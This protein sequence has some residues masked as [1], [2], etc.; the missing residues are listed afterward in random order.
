M[1]LLYFAHLLGKTTD[2]LSVWSSNLI[3]KKLLL[4]D[5]RRKLDFQYC[6][7]EHIVSQQNKWEKP[8]IYVNTGLQTT[9]LI[10]VILKAKS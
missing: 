4:K 9:Q 2:L 8:Q 5:H 10:R 1:L 6:N 7:K 3:L